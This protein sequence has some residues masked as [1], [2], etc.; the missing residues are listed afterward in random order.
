[1]IKADA[2]EILELLPHRDPFLFVDRIESIDKHKVRGFCI[3]RQDNAIFDGHFPEIPLVPGVCLV[4]SVAQVA[5]A[6][7]AKRANEFFPEDQL[8]EGLVGVL[9][10]IKKSLFHKPVFPDQ[11]IETLVKVQQAMSNMFLVKGLG[12]LNGEKKFSV[13]LN[14]AMAPRSS[15]DINDLNR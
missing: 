6:H 10:G 5:G 15:V 7:L 2:K 9:S 8:Q 13:E 1:M 4:E 11:E 3:W 12:K 14:I